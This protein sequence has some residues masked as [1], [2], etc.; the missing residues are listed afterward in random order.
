M[1]EKIDQGHGDPKKKKR[2]RGLLIGLCVFLSVILLV[3][4]GGLWYVH[5]L[6]GRI[7]YVDPQ[8]SYL[9]SEEAELMQTEELD[10]M[11]PDEDLPALE[12]I[13]IPSEAPSEPDATEGSQPTEPTDTQPTVPPEPEG[14]I[15]NILLIGQDRRE[16][17]G[18]CRS[19][20]I[21]LVT[22]NKS[23]GV[24]SLTS[25][26][27][28]AYVRI[29]GY[30]NYKINAAFQYGGMSLLN[31]TLYTNYG[32][33]VDGDIAVDFFQFKKLID[34]LGGVEI[35]LTQKEA[36]YMNIDSN[37][38][39]TAGTHILTGP[40]ALKYS[41]IR[42]ID[43]DYRRAERQRTVL[44]SLVEKFKDLSVLEML[45]I[46][47]EVLG[48]V[49]TNMSQSQ[50]I[51]LAKELFPMLSSSDFQQYQIPAKG[52]FKGGNVQVRPGLKGWFQY[53]IDFEANRRLLREI[54]DAD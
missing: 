40:Q 29:P 53:N 35:T 26:M 37:W 33:R 5:R 44:M 13:T 50:I 52:T 12:D 43:T 48:M 4:A 24:I 2:T 41:R 38:G 18:R 10:T 42:Y 21:I 49:Q 51:S 39:L 20:S 22:F 9:S 30:S 17:Q 27:R 15:V 34:M 7:E 25:F 16:G 6:L 31:E 47:E 36:E 32:V 23:T 54:F 1:E 8:E 45:P 28:D 46:L 14:D 19:D 11:A 3:L